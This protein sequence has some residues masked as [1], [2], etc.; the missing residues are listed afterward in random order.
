M[1]YESVEHFRRVHPDLPWI[2]SDSSSYAEKRHIFR[3]DNPS[4]P[5]AI[6]VP[7]KAED[8]AAII[9][10]V[11]Q[12]KIPVTVRSGGHDTWGRSIVQDGICIDMR[13]INFVEVSPDRKTARIG[14]GILTGQLLEVLEKEDLVAASGSVPDV[15]YISWATLTGYGPMSTGWGLGVDQIVEVE[16]VNAQGEIAPAGPELLAGFRGAGGHFGV[17]VSLKIK[18][19]ELKT[20]SQ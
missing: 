10:L 12:L 18:I 15:G 14:G 11:R 13:D 9:R 8:V 3:L 2:T 1:A 16:A 7:Q 4:V 6:A 20:V 5:R 17:A 19:Y